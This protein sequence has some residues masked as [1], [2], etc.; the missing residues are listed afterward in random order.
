MRSRNEVS[1]VRFGDAS[2]ERSARREVFG[3]RLHQLPRLYSSQGRWSRSW[4]QVWCRFRRGKDYRP[5]SLIACLV[6]KLSQRLQERNDL[7]LL[8]LRQAVK[9][10]SNL[11][12]FTAMVVDR[13][14]QVARSAIVQEFNS[15]S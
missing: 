12:R 9:A 6:K 14:V 3:R 4:I 13:F 7:G 11:I 1:I 15:R 8:F 5:H 10:F 2:S